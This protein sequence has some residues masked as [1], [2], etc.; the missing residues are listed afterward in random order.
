MK[1]ST[2][3]WIMIFIISLVGGAFTTGYI[4]SAISIGASGIAINMTL[5]AWIGLIFVVANTI[6]GNILYFRFLQTR[7]FNAM[8]FFSTIPTTAMFGFIIFTL[9]TAQNNQN[10]IVEVVKV[11]LRIN[12]TNYN[13]I[14]WAILAGIIYLIVMFFTFTLVSRPVRKIEKACT[15]LSY[16]EVKSEISIG[17]NKDFKE[18][19]YSLNKINDNYKQKD[20]QLTK[21]HSEFE[22]YIPKQIL[23]IFGKKNILELEVGEK[24]QKEVTTLFCDIR[25]SQ[26]VSSTL[27]MEENFNYINSYLNL[28]SPIVRKFN[29]YIDKY[30]GDGVLAVFTSADQA[31][32]CAHSIQKSIIQKNL[33]N[34]TMPSLDVGIGIN[35]SD[36]L[37]GVVGDEIRKSPSIISDTMDISTKMQEINKKYGS[38]I[39]FSK[40]TLTS[41]SNKVDLSYRY[42]GTIDMQDN[43]EQIPLFE[44]LYAYKRQKRE[45]LEQNKTAFE[46]GVR[47]YNNAKFEEAKQVFEEVY[48]KEK[49]DKV[50]YVYYNNC[51]EKLSPPQIK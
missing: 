26:A 47:K 35:T 36:V 5:P 16:G 20:L 21:T 42:I 2:K 18:I 37:F 30:L 29:G 46:E 48:K 3:I 22:K 38:V 15:K 24:A 40:N 6:S 43:N 13:N 25:N 8:L 10:Q 45:K 1:T 32:N 7:K 41:L 34:K 14:Y 9:L 44:S 17:G 33:E 27:S 19:E 39:I 11:A 12:N 49:D 31:I 28:V 50:C 4:F 23:Q 51:I